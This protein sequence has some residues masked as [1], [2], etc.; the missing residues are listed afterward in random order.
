MKMVIEGIM[1]LGDL[2]GDVI[3]DLLGFFE[4]HMSPSLE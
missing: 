2:A 4:A 3:A 1:T